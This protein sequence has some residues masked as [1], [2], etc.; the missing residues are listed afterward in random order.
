MKKHKLTKLMAYVYM[1]LIFAIIG[2]GIV[3]MA[4]KPFIDIGISVG[5]LFMSSTAGENEL[6]GETFDQPGIDINKQSGTIDIKGV[7][8]PEYA[9]AYGQLSCER[10]GLLSHVYWGDDNDLLREGAGT[11]LGSGIPGNNRTMLIAGHN[12]TIFS[13]LQNIQPGDVITFTTT[14][15]IYQYQI[16]DTKVL[17]SYD[18]T[19]YDMSAKTEQLVLYTCYP[20]ST[21]GSTNQRF[22]A[23][24]TKIMGPELVQGGGQS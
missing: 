17:D 20:F 14:Y 11:Y 12:T 4:A 16:T 22:F 13:P 23:Y 3:Y 6:K 8:W 19:A 24:G 2:Y 1:P 21:L 10:I 5:S 15:G 9:D 18:T 7:H